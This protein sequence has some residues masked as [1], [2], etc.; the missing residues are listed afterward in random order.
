MSRNLCGF[1]V[2]DGPILVT[3]ASGFVGRTL[4]EMFDLG[5]EDFAADASTEFTAP[6]GVKKI[7]WKLPGPPPDS[8][9]EV[10]HV[11]HLAGLSSVAHSHRGEETVISVNCRGTVSVALWVKKRCPG[12]R[13]LLASS[14]EVYMPSREPL[15]ETS[16]TGPRSPYGKSKLL[17]EEALGNTAESFVI[18]R[19]FPHF[20]P[21]QQGHFVLPSFCRRIITAIRNGEESIPAGNLL[22]VRDYLYIE[23]VVRAYA[24]LLSRGAAGGV[25]NVCSGRGHSIGELFDMLAAVGGTGL[26]ALTNQDLLRPGDQ[27]CQVGDPSALRKLGW[28]M[29]VPL[30][31]GLELLYRWWEERL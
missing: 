6:D 18:S 28:E 19:S 1:P 25:Y 17:A 16:P 15:A 30:E 12:A 2:E 23:D 9:G 29:E 31:M 13:I 21:G 11:V 20:G 22:A 10:R 24:C 4:M 27:F 5:T 7:P 26:R 3:G 14:A 8:L